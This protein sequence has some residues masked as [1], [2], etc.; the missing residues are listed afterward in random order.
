MKTKFLSVLMLIIILT[1]LILASCDKKPTFE[2]ACQ[3]LRNEIAAEGCNVTCEVEEIN[4]RESLIITYKVDTYESVFPGLLVSHMASLLE[5]KFK[6][7]AQALFK[8]LEN[9]A[10]YLFVV[11]KYD[12]SCYDIRTLYMD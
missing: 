2:D 12:S 1:T 4:L 9:C 7:T 11:D 5:D 10:V 3:S 6:P 8:D